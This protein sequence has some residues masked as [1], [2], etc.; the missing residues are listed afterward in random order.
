MYKNASDRS[1]RRNLTNEIKAYCEL[2][3]TD[4]L[5]EVHKMA[6]MLHVGEQNAKLEMGKFLN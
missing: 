4:N 5:R 6:K 3:N 1:I 2:L